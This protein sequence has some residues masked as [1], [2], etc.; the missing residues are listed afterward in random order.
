MGGIPL[1]NWGYCKPKGIKYRCWFAVKGLEPPKECK[2]SESKYGRVIYIK[3]DHDPRMFPP[4]P[5]HSHS[6]CTKA[7]SFI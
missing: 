2:C 3:P 4:V 7:F 1:V 5:R 6:F